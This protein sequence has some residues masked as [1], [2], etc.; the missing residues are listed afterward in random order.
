M[1]PYVHIGAE[2][3]PPFLWPPWSLMVFTVQG[4]RWHNPIDPHGRS[5]LMLQRVKTISLVAAAVFALLLQA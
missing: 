5:P 3:T 2:I 1:V 4:P